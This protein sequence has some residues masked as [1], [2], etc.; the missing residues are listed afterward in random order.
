MKDRT[1]EPPKKTPSDHQKPLAIHVVIQ[2]TTNAVVKTPSTHLCRW[3]RNRTITHTTINAIDQPIN[4]PIFIRLPRSSSRW[5][6]W[7]IKRKSVGICIYCR[8]TI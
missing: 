1:I 2:A 8:P 6:D 7:F 3:R 4:V 5:R